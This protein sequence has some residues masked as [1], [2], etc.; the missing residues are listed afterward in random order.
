M[1]SVTVFSPA[2]INLF[3][4]V[5]GVREDGFHSLVSV[6]VPLSF[7][8]TLWVG[9]NLARDGDIL[10]CSH[11]EVPPGASNLIVRAAEIFRENTGVKRNFHFRLMKRI[12]MEA[13]LGGGSSNAIAAL[14]GLETLCG[15]RLSMGN[16]NEIAS[17]LG[18]DCPLFLHGGPSVVRGRGESVEPLSTGELS[19]FHG[20]KVLVIKPPFGINTGWAYRQFSGNE[21]LFCPERDAEQKILD[22]R[23]GK[24]TL[25]ELLQNNFESV[26]FYKYLALDALISGL[27]DNFG[28]PCLLSGS[29]SA[30]FCISKSAEILDRAENYVRECM[31]DTISC[32][33]SSFRST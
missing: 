11:P 30:F 19:D 23:T 22:W 7:G 31:G 4:A 3:L 26:V 12:P 2:K 21:S 9:F 33:V 1:K 25:P 28:L 13:G 29:G 15:E 14:A 32:I 24:I 5:T 8:D 20:Y 6:A 16:R 27:R 10:E 17:A 18:S